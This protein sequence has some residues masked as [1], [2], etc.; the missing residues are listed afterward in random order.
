MDAILT[1]EERVDY[2]IA[3]TSLDEQVAQLSNNAPAIP[4]L[5]IPMYQW[6][7]DDVHGVGHAGP[8]AT[9]LPNGCGMGATWS[10][11]EARLSTNG[12]GITIYGPNLN[13][14]RDPRWGRGQETF[15]E[16]P[17]LTGELVVSW[18]TGAQANKPR[19][20]LGPDGGPLLSGLCCKHFAAYD[21]NKAV[22]FSANVSARSMWE[23]YMPAFQRC[24]VEAQATHVMCSY[25]SLLGEPTCGNED[26]LT[27][28][29][30]DQWNF[31]G[32]VVSDY[33][34]WTAMQGYLSDSMV[35]VAA[36]GL[37]AG[38]DQEGG[39]T[40]AIDNITIAIS[41]GKTTTE[42]VET[43]F[44]RS[45][46]IRIRLGMF[47]PPGEVPYDSIDESAL[48]SAENIE[49]N[50]AAA[51]A[52][53][54]LLK[55]DNQALPLVPENSSSIAVI[56]VQAT[57]AGLLV[58]NYAEQAADNNWGDSVLA[59]IEARLD[60]DVAY[61][62]GCATIDCNSTLGFEE[63]LKV[64]QNAETI[65]VMLGLAANSMGGEVDGPSDEREGH[66]RTAIELPGF[67][68]ELVKELRAASPGKKLIGV[69][70]HGGTLALGNAKEQ[71][72][73]IL[74]A[75][76]P[77]IEG[78][79]AIAATLFGDSNPAGRSASTWYRSTSVLPDAWL[80]GSMDES[81]GNGIT[82]RFIKDQSVVDFPFGWG[83]SYTTFHYS[84]LTVEKNVKQIDPC[85][86]ITLSVT[87][88]NVR[89]LDGEEVVQV[90]LKLPDATVETTLVRLVSF[91]RVM[92]KSGDSA[93][94]GLKIMPQ[95][96]AVIYDDEESDP[97]ND[98]RH[99][100]SGLLQLFVGGGQPGYV[101]TQHVEVD[102]T[103]TALLSSCDI[104]GA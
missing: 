17:G 37:N 100:E 39:G 83:L 15:G 81:D 28:I 23:T 43:A 1:V 10:K 34:A 79:N 98:T 14:V 91:K 6:L 95:A 92:I 4:H 41:Q 22:E 29:L 31:T 76:Y 19:E 86:S 42:K 101:D 70:L 2:V 61:A 52:S 65:I 62:P 97:Y 99:M 24:V 36:Q 47:D 71:L 16:C 77:G 45:L 68:G 26:L 8:N 13:L 58:G 49:V 56:G 12:A 20:A 89:D 93:R 64:S 35:D 53:M 59:A 60:A 30:R 84:D 63:A 80:E 57:M 88:A 5:G 46:R 85:E 55:N 40:E 50:R 67:Q 27:D 102:V 94:V 90:Y 11:E 54:T 7:N 66:D 44:R 78:A 21:Q 25:N 69:L 48:Q 72:D 51:L 18:V 9:I 74:T 33:D 82:Y 75:W 3:H 38:L 104:G 96:M 73:G 103:D 87:V 32:F